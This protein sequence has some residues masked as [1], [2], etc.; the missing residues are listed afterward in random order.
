MSDVIDAALAKRFQH[1][2]EQEQWSFE[3]FTT[4]PSPAPLQGGAA[5]G[6]AKK[7]DKVVL[8]AAAGL[9]LSL[10]GIAY[11]RMPCFQR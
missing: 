9:I 7:V 3:P 8:G 2:I 1:I 10:L 4:K 6:G 5:A 11:L